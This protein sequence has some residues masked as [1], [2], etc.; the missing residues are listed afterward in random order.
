MASLALLGG[1]QVF[2]EAPRQ[3]R[4]LELQLGE[5]GLYQ[6]WQ[7]ER[8]TFRVWW[9]GLR[10]EV[11]MRMGLP[12]PPLRVMPNVYG[13]EDAYAATLDGM[14]V[15]RGTTPMLGTLLVYMQKL[16]LQLAGL[17]VRSVFS[18]PL[19]GS[20]LSLVSD[21]GN[22]KDFLRRAGI[23]FE[24]PLHIISLQ[25][26]GELIRSPEYVLGVT[27]VLSLE[28]QIEKN[29]PGLLSQTVDREFLTTARLA[30]VLRMLIRDGISTNDVRSIIES[31]ADYCATTGSSLVTENEFDAGD[32]VQ[33]IRARKKGLLVDRALTPRGSVKYIVIASESAER[34]VQVVESNRTD[35][36]I[37]KELEA[38]M[39]PLFERGLPPLAI[40]VLSEYRVKV[41]LALRTAKIP[42]P[43]FSFDELPNNS[44]CIA[45][46]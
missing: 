1:G 14:P 45:V 31:I 38:L 8:E 3:M 30:E 19:Y 41:A 25:I 5:H 17:S 23:R 42:M 11:H 9:E 12:C 13:A 28:T 34:F 24:N 46:L 26:V 35:K 20:E 37:I 21:D 43:V 27:E 33:F 39:K 22:T 10:S 18:H 29:F 2:L 4:M 6:L 7:Q 16:P 36:A 44:E 32:M 15:I 40:A